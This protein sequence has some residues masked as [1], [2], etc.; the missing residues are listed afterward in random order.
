ML[1]LFNT[2]G[3]RIETFRS[4]NEKVVN[5]FTCGPSVYQRSHIGNFRT[6]LFEDILVRYLEYSGYKVKRGMNFTNV[7]DKAIKEAEKRRM[8]VKSLTDENI[9]AFIQEMER[10]R[11]KIPDYLPKA[12][13]ALDEATAIIES[14]LDLGIAYWYRGNVYFNPL[15]YP[16]FGELYGLDMSTWPVQKRRFHKDTYPGMRWNRGDDEALQILEGQVRK[17]RV[18]GSEE[19]VTEYKFKD[20]RELALKAMG[21]I[22]GQLNLQLEI[23]KVFYDHKAVAEFQREVLQ[24]I[25]DADT[26]TA[27]RIIEN[28]KK[29]GA[30]YSAL[31]FD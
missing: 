24:A 5:I 15:K 13:G 19:E 2:L 9:K 21:E 18:R 3:K 17:V 1:K 8:R 31:D 25:A 11:M 23:F 6:F 4:A 29:T 7:E 27:T 26:K 28:L 20:P 10:L 14:L 12:S 16:G 30:I 22:R